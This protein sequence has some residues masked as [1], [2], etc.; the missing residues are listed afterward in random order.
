[1]APRCSTSKGSSWRLMPPTTRSPSAAPELLE[2][3][4]GFGHPEAG[5]AVVLGEPQREH[6]GIGELA[7]QPSVDAAHVGQG[8]HPL[9]RE[10]PFAEL[11]HRLLQGL[12]VGREREVHQA[13]GSPRIRSAMMLRWI[14]ELPAAMV[15][16]STRSRSSTKWPERSWTSSRERAARSSTRSARSPMRWM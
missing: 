10:A 13:F 1:M 14:C 9:H 5:A 15:K 7:P 8:P 4:C 2:D 16:A 6:A 12:L 11:A 3:Q